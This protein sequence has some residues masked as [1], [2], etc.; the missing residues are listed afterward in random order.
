MENKTSGKITLTGHIIV[1]H[2][3]IALVRAG[4]SSHV[5]LTRRE[6][7]CLLFEVTESLNQP[8][9]FDVH[10]EFVDRATFDA[11]QARSAASVWGEI[12]DG[13]PRTYEIIEET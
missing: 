1:P 3:R 13:I 5:A 2:H 9:R 8:G 12:A 6:P 4:L 10:E 7:G 11:H